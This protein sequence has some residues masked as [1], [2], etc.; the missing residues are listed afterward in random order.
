MIVLSQVAVTTNRNQGG[1]VLF[2]IAIPSSYDRVTTYSCIGTD[3]NVFSTNNGQWMI[4][5]NAFS[6]F[7]ECVGNP[8]RVE[9]ISQ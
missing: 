1:E 2:L 6:R 8:S 3:R 7:I 9:S 4:E 5:Y